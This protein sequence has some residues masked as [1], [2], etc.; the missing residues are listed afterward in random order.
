VSDSAGIR[1]TEDGQKAPF[2]LCNKKPIWNEATQSYQLNYYGRASIAS[3]KNFQLIHPDN[4]NQIFLQLGK[5]SKDTFILDFQYPF[6]PVLA[7]GTAMGSLASK[8]FSE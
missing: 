6:S 4:D 2:E 1:G 7:F 3:V 8:R 5:I